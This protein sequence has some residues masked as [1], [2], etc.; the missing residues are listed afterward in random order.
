LRLECW[1]CTEIFYGYDLELSRVVCR[2]IYVI[3]TTSI[4]DKEI[5][6]IRSFRSSCKVSQKWWLTSVSLGSLE[7]MGDYGWKP[8]LGKKLPRPPS[9]SIKNMPVISTLWEE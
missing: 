3:S 4:L 2:G 1:L 8:T 5:V 6:R 7:A 9:Q